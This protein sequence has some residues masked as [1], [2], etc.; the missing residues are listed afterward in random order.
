[1]HGRDY[2][3][4]GKNGSCPLPGFAYGDNLG[5]EDSM[6]RRTRKQWCFRK[7]QCAD[8]TRSK[9]GEEKIKISFTRTGEI[10]ET[11]CPCH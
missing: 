7:H 4:L 10:N 5:D 3:E 2:L 6:A 1:M 11:H 9:G 8:F